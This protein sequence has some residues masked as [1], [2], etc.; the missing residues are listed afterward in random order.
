M[1]AREHSGNLP[2]LCAAPGLHRAA[3]AAPCLSVC[4]CAG[5]APWAPEVCVVVFVSAPTALS[6]PSDKLP[7][8]GRRRAAL[9]AAKFQSW[10][11]GE[12]KEPAGSGTAQREDFCH[13]GNNP[14]LAPLFLRAF[15]P[16]PVF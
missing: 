3:K 16:V 9:C 5:A 7:S 14:F 2:A 1:Q 12:N 13:K 10:D 11:L 4:L 6:W 15:L 8:L